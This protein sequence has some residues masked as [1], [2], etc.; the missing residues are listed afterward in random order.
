MLWIDL[1]DGPF[2]RMADIPVFIVQRLGQQQQGIFGVRGEFT[3]RQ[4]SIM[5]HI[6]V[7]VF[8]GNHES[9]NNASHIGRA[10]AQFTNGFASFNDHGT[11]ELFQPILGGAPTAPN[12]QQK[13]E[14]ESKV[15]HADS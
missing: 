8:Q 7:F 11:M 10:P 3:E 9:R 14:K 1:F 15:A 2:R 12:Q 5:T 4:R 6:G 13:H